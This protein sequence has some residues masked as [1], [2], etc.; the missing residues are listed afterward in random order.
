MRS[1]RKDTKEQKWIINPFMS[2]FF[3]QDYQ[4]VRINQQKYPPNLHEKGQT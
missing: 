4:L 1:S 2:I 3:L